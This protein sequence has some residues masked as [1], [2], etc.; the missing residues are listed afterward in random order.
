MIRD[1]LTECEELEILRLKSD[2][3]RQDYKH[4]LIRTWLKERIVDGLIIHNKLKIPP[5]MS[6]EVYVEG[7]RGTRQDAE[8]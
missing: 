7:F 3:T 1:H 2:K 4:Y 5:S 8:A 6:K